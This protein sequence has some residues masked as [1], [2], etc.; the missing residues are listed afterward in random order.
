MTASGSGGLS[1]VGVLNPEKLL[2]SAVIRRDSRLKRVLEKPMWQI[3]CFALTG[4]LAALLISGAVSAVPEVD[5]AVP[6]YEKSAGVSGVLSSVGSDTMANLL[7]LWAER[8]NR[9]YPDVDFQ[10]QATGSSTAPPALSE[11][12]S[13]LAPMSRRMKDLEIQAFKKSHGYQ[14]TAIRVAIDALAVFVHKDNPLKGMTIP[15]LDAIFSL[16]RRC[17]YPVDINRWGQ[18]GVQG[19]TEKSDIQLFGRNAA[20]GT[21]DYF[22]K[23]ALC[24]GNFKANINEQPGSSSVVKLVSTSAVAIGYSAIGY[25]TSGVKA[26]PLA[27][28]EGDNFVDATAENA[29]SGKYPLARFLYIYVDKYP[30][31]PLP[32]LEQEYIKLVLSQSGQKIVVKDGYIPLPVSVVEQELDALK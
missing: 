29:I 6:I 30:D 27:K 15:Q 25:K 14:P 4:S 17:G 19:V 13:N 9:E 32:R 3:N 1:F 8:F 11:R 5:R 26:V 2:N 24:K 18:V 31:Q 23:K 22:K 12:R 21:Y 7:T 10:I 20:S 16:T 28:T